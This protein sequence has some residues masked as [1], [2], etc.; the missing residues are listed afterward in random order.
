MPS[1]YRLHGV[2][3]TGASVAR[4]S[5]GYRS[6]RFRACLGGKQNV[7]ARKR[8]SIC[9][10][11]FTAPLAFRE[12][13]PENRIVS[14]TP[15]SPV[16][17]VR[18]TI[19]LVTLNGP[20]EKFWGA[21]L[22]LTPAGASLRGIDLNSFEDFASMVRAGEPANAGAVFFPMHRIERIEMDIRSGTIPSLSERFTAKS[23]KDAASVLDAA[24]STEGGQR[25]APSGGVKDDLQ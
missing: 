25:G 9:Y 18:G 2:Y 15:Q 8:T 7:P 6:A 12:A 10:S 24:P 14:S 21:I 22:D 4:I 17:F 23:G 16:F 5:S 20:R 3:A 1:I 11:F 19:V 13:G